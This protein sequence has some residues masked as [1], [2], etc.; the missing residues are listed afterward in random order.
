M[1]AR[2]EL[3]VKMGMSEAHADAFISGIQN[4]VLNS[5]SKANGWFTDADLHSLLCSIQAQ[6]KILNVSGANFGE[7]AENI[8]ESFKN[9]KSSVDFLSKLRSFDKN[10]SDFLSTIFTH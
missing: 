7:K 10:D 2:K 4:E 5:H 3:L 1:E 6:P 9:A 8:I